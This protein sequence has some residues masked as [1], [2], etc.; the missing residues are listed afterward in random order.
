M[1]SEPISEDFRQEAGFFD[2]IIY[3]EDLEISDVDNWIFQHRV[4]EICTAVK[5]H[6][7]S[8]L[9]DKKG[10]EKVVYLD[11]DIVVFNSLETIEKLLDQHPIILTPHQSK[12]DQEIQDIIN[13]EIGSLRWGVFN[14][15]FFA[16]RNKGQG[17]EFITW[18]KE[19]LKN[20]C[21][22]DIPFGLFTDQRW[23]DLAPIFFD[24]LYIL[25]ESG[26]DVATWNLSHRKLSIN[27]DG[28]ILVDNQLL[29]FYH[30]S[31]YDSG[32]GALM[33]DVK[34]H[35]N[36]NS[37]VKEIWNWYDKQ[38]NLYGQRELGKLEWFYNYFDN[39]EKITDEMRTLYRIRLDL[40]E[41]YPNP[42]DTI[43][44]NGGFYRWWK[45]QYPKECISQF[46][47]AEDEKAHITEMRSE[48]Y[49]Y[50]IGKANNDLPKEYIPLNSE[51]LVDINSLVKLIAFYLPQ[52]HPIPENDIWWGK[53]FTEWTNVTKAVP[54]FPGHYQP[55]LPGELGFYDLRVVDIQKRQV[56]L[57][58]QYGI[59]GFAFYYYWFAGKRLLEHP[60]EQFF[61]NKDIDF[62][63]CLVWANENWTR[64]WDGQENDI[65]MEQIHTPQTD[66]EFIRSIEPLI[67]DERYI[68]VGNRPVIIVYRVGLM[69]DP[70]ATAERWREYCIK[71]GIGNPYLVAAQTFGFEDPNEVG[72]D[73]AVQFPPHNQYH[74][75]RFLINPPIKYANPNYNSYVFSY[76]EIVKYNEEEPED[77]PYTLFKTVFPSWDNEPRKPGRG[78]IFAESTPGLYRRWLQAVCK[79]TV[80]N[81]KTEER[82]VFINA[83]NEWGEGA[84][85]EPD[86]RFG[87]AYLQATLDVLRG[88][89]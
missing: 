16:V 65:L 12:P 13:N 36:E 71:Q 5:G 33:V 3:F 51:S 42:F 49:D 54:Q 73:A 86:R 1:L 58:K 27:E 4:V 2:N 70:K 68:R 89:R 74:S 52:F 59:H 23:C 81:Q 10:A 32:A 9:F 44:K 26:Y 38:L 40:Q 50:L 30:F 66:V 88:L 56:E 20:F 34:T 78:T 85:L 64:R 35:E 80:I 75:A 39:G 22:D 43:C 14:L 11:P 41:H 77:T 47:N 57:A 45:D 53:G 17:I 18:W 76:P 72:F 31:G 60:L 46:I 67:R 48:I 19:R 55:H 25:R 7:A 29:R 82:L 69:P 63:F 8:Y 28:E 62:P 61:Q 79:W 37:I 15:G 83:W 84:H 24:Q 87:Y 6:V 21:R